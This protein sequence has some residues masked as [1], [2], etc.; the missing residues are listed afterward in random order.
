MTNLSIQK[1]HS[2]AI[3]RVIDFINESDRMRKSYGTYVK[4]CVDT[5]LN[6]LKQIM[7]KNIVSTI[8]DDEVE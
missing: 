7:F 6:V 3:S 5:V 8:V 1:K 2:F 4:V